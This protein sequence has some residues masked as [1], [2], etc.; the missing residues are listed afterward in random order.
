MAATLAVGGRLIWNAI[1]IRVA[2]RK[3]IQSSG[4]TWQKIQ[5]R[6][7]LIPLSTS[8]ENIVEITRHRLRGIHNSSGS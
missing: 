4:A 6:R 1:Q 7:L 3:A 8:W 5:A 2:Y